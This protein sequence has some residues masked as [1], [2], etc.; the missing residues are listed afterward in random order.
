MFFRLPPFWVIV[1][2]LS[3]SKL[4]SKKIKIHQI[5][6]IVWLLVMEPYYSQSGVYNEK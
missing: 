4:K 5:Q 1:F 3:P 2:L 6:K